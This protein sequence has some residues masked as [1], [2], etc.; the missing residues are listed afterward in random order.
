MEVYRLYMTLR[1]EKARL[2]QSCIQSH[3]QM[4]Y[5]VMSKHVGDLAL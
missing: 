1:V 5:Q 2:N 3:S 4:T